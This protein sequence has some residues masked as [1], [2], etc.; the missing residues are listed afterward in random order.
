MAS[1]ISELEQLEN[2]DVI[3]YVDECGNWWVNGH[4]KLFYQ[5]RELE[6]IGQTYDGEVCMID[7][8]GEY[9]GVMDAKLEDFQIK[10]N[11]TEVKI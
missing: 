8:L 4:C 2:L 3:T 5:G 7:I 11:G 1:F 6:Q 10:I 9:F